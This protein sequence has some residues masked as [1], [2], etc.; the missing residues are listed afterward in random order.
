MVMAVSSLML[1]SV[2]GYG[3]FSMH[4]LS[5][6]IWLHYSSV[7]MCVYVCGRV[8]ACVRACVLN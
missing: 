6:Y 8:R 1:A 7:L 5:T 2:V 3:R 4:M